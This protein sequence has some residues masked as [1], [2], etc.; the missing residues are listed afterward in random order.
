MTN[1]Q[2]ELVTA[3]LKRRHPQI[4]AIRFEHC[5]PF[6]NDDLIYIVKGLIPYKISNRTYT[7]LRNYSAYELLYEASGAEKKTKK[8]RKS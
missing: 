5:D 3:Y 6:D 1:E 2:K 8:R 4:L 7:L